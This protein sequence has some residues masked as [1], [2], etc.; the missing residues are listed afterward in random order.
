MKGQFM[1]DFEI[2]VVL[3]MLVFGI[4]FEICLSSIAIDINRLKKEIAKRNPHS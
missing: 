2:V 3:M 1:S 4:V